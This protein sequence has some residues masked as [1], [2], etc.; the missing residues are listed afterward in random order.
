MAEIR[1]Q[2]FQHQRSYQVLSAIHETMYPSSKVGCGHR[3]GMNLAYSTI[4]RLSKL[5]FHRF[6]GDRVREWLFKLEQFFSLDFTPEELKVRIASSHFDGVAKK[7]HQSLLDTDFGVKLLS[8][9]KTYKLVLQEHF[10][11]V[12]DD[13]IAEFK[14]LKETN[15]IEEYHKK[16]ELLRTRVKL[17][18]AYLVRTYLDGLQTDTQVNVQMFQ[19]QTVEQ[20]LLI[21]RLYEQAHRRSNI[22]DDCDDDQPLNGEFGESVEHRMVNLVPEAQKENPKLENH[23]GGEQ[24]VILEVDGDVEK[25][26]NVVSNTKLCSAHQVF[27][28][29]PSKEKQRKCLKAWKFKFKSTSKRSK[30]MDDMF[31]FVEEAVLLK[32]DPKET[33]WD[34]VKKEFK[35]TMAACGK[36]RVDRFKL[37]EEKESRLQVLDLNQTFMYHQIGHGVDIL[38]VSKMV[39]HDK[40]MENKKTWT[41]LRVR[42]HDNLIWKEDI[43][44]ESRS[45]PS[46]YIVKLG[47]ATITCKN[48][49]EKSYDKN[50]DTVAWRNRP[51]RSEISNEE[52]QGNLQ[53][54]IGF[55][56]SRGKNSTFISQAMA[57]LSESKVW[58]EKQI[59]TLQ[60]LKQ[61]NKSQYRWTQVHDVNRFLMW[62]HLHLNLDCEEPKLAGRKRN[63]GL[64]IRLHS[65]QKQRKCPKSWMFKFKTGSKLA[66][67]SHLKRHKESGLGAQIRGV[68]KQ[69]KLL[70]LSLCPSFLCRAMLRVTVKQ[71]KHPKTW[72]FKFKLAIG[73]YVY[74]KLQPYRQ[75][76]V[77]LRPNQKLAPKYFGPYRI[78]DKCGA[79]AYQLDLPTT[80]QVH[81]VFHVS[82]LKVLMGNVHT[83][84]HLPSVLQDAFVREPE[85][86][87]ER[88]MVN[89]QGQ[90]ATKVLVKWKTEPVEE[91]TW[92]FLFDLKQKYPQFDA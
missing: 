13:P 4:T 41:K 50:L 90:A 58:T 12:L 73:D 63:H 91:A 70:L 30:S 86:I 92:E 11:E 82:Q 60:I 74:F 75:Q 6:S 72:S 54:R 25:S 26:Q 7:W 61:V 77:V 48:L 66:G 34:C 31:S 59:P 49:L 45:R 18:E 32:K 35:E 88:K 89:R 64:L 38:L 2:M 8:D 44:D 19:P 47:D 5:D 62:R 10:A 81:P 42:K 79:V 67:T 43:S 14:Q 15:G 40:E 78:V 1:S 76:S 46:R 51:G 3:S 17:P 80:S 55:S 39:V 37:A 9:W 36:N 27:D 68:R 22:D 16:F 57:L 87:I 33:I 23:E 24:M 21:G 83:S 71:S 65:K 85:R 69:S 56:F 29:M 52:D 84:T 20:C 28:Q 53:S